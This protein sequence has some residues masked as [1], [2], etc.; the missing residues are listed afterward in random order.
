MTDD[1][2]VR[3]ASAARVIGEFTEIVEEFLRVSRMP[4]SRFGREAAGS[5]D[6]VRHLREGRDFRRSTLQKVLDYIGA[7]P[8]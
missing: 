1:V 2:L 7:A 4:T 6:F 8:L 5:V 3:A